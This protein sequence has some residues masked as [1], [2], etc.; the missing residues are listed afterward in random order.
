MYYYSLNSVVG[1]DGHYNVR[2]G[3][4]FGRSENYFKS[5]LHSLIADHSEKISV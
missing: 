4:E 3:M 2:K 5:I 1:I